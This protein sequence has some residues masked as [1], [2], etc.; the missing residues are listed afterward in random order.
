MEDM[1]KNLIYTSVGVVSLTAEKVQ[2][3]IDKLVDDNKISSEEGK[4]IVEE[5]LKN[6]RVKA[7]E[8]ESQLK[9]I[10]EKTMSSFD[11]ITKDEAK[12]LQSKVE[13]L[14]KEVAK[15]KK[16]AKPS[17]RKTAATV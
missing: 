9:S 4:K 13:E 2:G 8:F 3:V 1:I 7:E 14:E 12:S 17:T 5:F 15:L 10:V 6:S 16:D 11:F